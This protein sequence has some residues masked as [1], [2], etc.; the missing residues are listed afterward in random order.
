MIFGHGKAKLENVII[1]KNKNEAEYSLITTF[2]FF[3]FIVE[4]QSFTNESRAE[5]KG[6]NEYHLL[7]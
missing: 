4:S 1:V 3:L 6:V 5:L 2:R 7:T